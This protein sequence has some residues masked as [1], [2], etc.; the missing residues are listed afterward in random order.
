MENSANQSASMDR[1][2]DEFRNFYGIHEMPFSL[3][4]NT[5]FYV[6]LPSHNEC[7]SMLLFAIAS[8]DGFIKVTGEVGTGKTLLCRRLLNTLDD[9]QFYSAYIPNPRLNPVELK[10]AVAKELQVPELGWVSDD[11]LLDAI[12]KRLIEL[13][14]ANKKVVLVIDEAQA[15]PEESLE[16][17]RL[18]T[19]LETETSKLMQIVLFGQPELDEILAQHHFRQLRQRITFSHSL[20]RLNKT[21]IG[22]YIQHRMNVAGYNG[23]PVFDRSSISLLHKATLGTPRLINIVCG[24]ALLIAFGKGQQ[25]VK[26]AMVKSA[27]NDTEGVVYRSHWLMG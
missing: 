25:R 8:G 2:I 23:E 26:K 15:L 20:S 9:G 14:L 5:Q 3:V 4:P 19:N 11:N 18:L 6:G 1:I 17:L 21:G 16:E 22:Q 13:A 7:F 10:R 27:L 24:K 12:N